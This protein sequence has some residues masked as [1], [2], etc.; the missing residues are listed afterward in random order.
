MTKRKIVKHFL[1]WL[2]SNF[3]KQKNPTAEIVSI[4][5]VPII[6]AVGFFCLIK[7]EGNKT[8]KR[9]SVQQFLFCHSKLIITLTPNQPYKNQNVTNFI[10]R[11]VYIYSTMDHLL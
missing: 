10:K 6:T 2:P 4:K 1:V 9:E 7:L 5:Y 3:I 8:T 11:P